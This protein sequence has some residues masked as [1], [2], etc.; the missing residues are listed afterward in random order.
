MAS[1]EFTLPPAAV[2][3]RQGTRLSALQE[4]CA[5]NFP[6]PGSSGEEASDSAFGPRIRQLFDHDFSRLAVVTVDD[7]TGANHVGYV[8]LAGH[9]T[10]LTGTSSGFTSLP[11]EKD[12][13]FAPDGGSV[14]FTYRDPNGQDH[15]ASRDLSADHRL[16]EQWSGS[17]AAFGDLGL[18]LGGTRCTVWSEGACTSVRTEGARS[19]TSTAKARTWW[20]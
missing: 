19:D 1:V 15:I 6:N 3:S 13:L 12:A 9:F 17:S 5:G 8:D 16:T 14:W 18:S 10:D 20:L 7:K 11:K 2:G 4:L